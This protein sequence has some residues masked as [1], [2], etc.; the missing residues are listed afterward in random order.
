MSKL[1]IFLVTATVIVLGCVIFYANPFSATTD[2]TTENRS[3][4]AVTHV[5]NAPVSHSTSDDSIEK[6]LNDGS[7]PLR[8]KIDHAYVRG[9]SSTNADFITLQKLLTKDLSRDE[10]VGA[11]RLFGS[12]YF[13]TTD[14]TLKSAIL[15]ELTKHIQSEND[16]EVGKSAAL[17]FSRLPFN[18]NTRTITKVA[19]TRGLFT[20]N[21]YF[22]ELVHISSAAPPAE[23]SSLLTEISDSKNRYASEVL[24]SA[25]T[26]S[27]LEKLTPSEKATLTQF[28]KTNEPIFEGAPSSFALTDAVRYEQWFLAIESLARTSASG[29]IIPAVLARLSAPDT[30]PRK[31]LTFF[32]SPLSGEAVKAVAY[33]SQT[34]AIQAVANTYAEKY[35]KNLPIQEAAIQMNNSLK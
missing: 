11:L 31:I 28:L 25:F 26:G 14:L 27:S 34:S 5:V 23:R 6:L 2:K 19:Y 29:N 10:K 13:G 20:A 7:A 4:L 15:N 32:M 35:P 33:R 30:D 16:I 17:T 18:E 9:G 8:E 3:E 24:A 22:G 1:R 21:E 12:V